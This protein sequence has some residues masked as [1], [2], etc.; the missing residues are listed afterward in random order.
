ML[1]FFSVACAESR[2]RPSL[3]G[4]PHVVGLAV[5]IALVAAI[6]LPLATAA[7]ETEAYSYSKKVDAELP[8]WMGDVEP[9][10]PIHEMSIPGTHDS[11]AFK[12][13]ES[14]FAQSRC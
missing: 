4:A 3:R 8:D 7:H 12:E 9:S 13:T 2:R 5:G 10:T 14:L 6:G 1:K 11:A